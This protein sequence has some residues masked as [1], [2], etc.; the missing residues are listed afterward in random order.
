MYLPNAASLCAQ[1]VSNF[2]TFSEWQI[3]TI[4]TVHRRPCPGRSRRQRKLYTRIYMLLYGILK[5]K[6]MKVDILIWPDIMMVNCEDS[7]SGYGIGA[8]M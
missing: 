6:K 1:T 4:R 2:S 5:E 3:I 7:Y 8:Y